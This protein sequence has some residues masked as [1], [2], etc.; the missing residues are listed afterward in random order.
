MLFSFYPVWGSWI[1]SLMPFINFVKFCHY[2]LK[3]CLFSYSFPSGHWLPMLDVTISSM[4]FNFSVFSL[5]DLFLHHS[6]YFILTCIHL[7]ILSSAM[8]VLLWNS[9]IK[10][11]ISVMVTFSSSIS[12]LFFLNNFQFFAKTLLTLV[13]VWKLPISGCPSDLFKWK[14]LLVFNYISWCGYFFIVWP[15]AYLQNRL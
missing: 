2:L 7:L 8:P 12:I 4:Y 10:I 13:C 1:C 11:L 14:F 5:F 9:S 3:Y 6:G 15:T